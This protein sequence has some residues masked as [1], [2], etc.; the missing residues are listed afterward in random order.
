MTVVPGRGPV[1]N[2]SDLLVAAAVE[3]FGIL[4]ILKDMVAIPIA[5]GRLIRLL[6]PWCEPFGGYH[7]YYPGRQGTAALELFKE[8]LR[9]A[10]RPT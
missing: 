2:D 5:D 4:Y 6:E 7:L 10:A 9:R 3:G 1:L 8:S